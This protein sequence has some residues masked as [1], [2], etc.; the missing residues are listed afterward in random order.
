MNIFLLVNGEETGPY[1]EDQ[2][3][4]MLI[5][6]EVSLSN[7]AWMDGLT[8]WYPLKNFSEFYIQPP[9]F[10]TLEKIVAVEKEKTKNGCTIIIIAAILFFLFFIIMILSDIKR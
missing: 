1:T 5:N 7:Y 6:S 10:V 8:E 2:V 9:E 3:R 4:T